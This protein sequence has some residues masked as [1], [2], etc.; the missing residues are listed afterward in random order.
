MRFYKLFIIT[1]FLTWIGASPILAG[2]IPAGKDPT[3]IRTG[4]W[5]GDFDLTSGVGFID[6]GKMTMEN[7]RLREN[8]TLNLLYKNPTFQFD[9]SI[10]TSFEK[11]ITDKTRIVLNSSF[12]GVIWNEESG[13]ARNGF[14]NAGA[15]WN[16]D[17]RNSY[18]VRA[19]FSPNHSLVDNST[20]K[21]TLLSTTTADMRLEERSTSA[22][23]SSVK[24]NSS[25]FL[26]KTRFSFHT[27]LDAG[28][29]MEKR[30]S[31]W[32][33]AV[34]KGDDEIEEMDI[35]DT[36]RLTPHNNRYNSGVS[37]TFRDSTLAGIPSLVAEA[38]LRLRGSHL[39]DH[40]SGAIETGDNEW[41][42][43]LRLRENFNY[44]EIYAEP[45][46]RLSYHKKKYG[47]DLNSTFQQYGNHLTDKGKDREVNW[48]PPSTIG[49]I[50][51]YW[52]PAPAHNLSVGGSRSIFHP[53][54]QQ[55]CWYDRQGAIEG[56]LFRGDPDLNPTVMTSGFL[57][58]Q[59]TIKKFRFTSR[60]TLTHTSDEIEQFFTDEKVDG[61]SYTIFKWDN[62]A[63]GDSFG[64]Q[65]GVSWSG[66]IIT[67][68]LNA[69]YLQ[70][71]RHKY[72]SGDMI[73][74]THRWITR[75]AVGVHPGHGW[76]FDVNGS[77]QGDIV[78]FYSI[79]KEYVSV[80]ARI[81]KRLG[82]ITLSL[83]GRDLL[84]RKRVVKVLSEDFSDSWEE[85][86]RM[87]RRLILLG[88]KWNF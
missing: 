81:S 21:L 15:R 48:R 60:S 18:S 82:K 84:D 76:D 51:F 28:T 42:D 23:S 69:D 19:S 50:R 8:G 12:F 44:I 63:Y 74:D 70:E 47:A 30:T 71:R 6:W 29:S 68:S 38:G 73:K 34:V 46:V 61:R 13:K 1:A 31:E 72:G 53:S 16:P 86:S 49:D 14:I 7:A 66:K 32:A 80:N 25:H 55:I 2:P 17:K 3:K 35:G 58:Y 20:A 37:L 85:E 62:T 45:N 88:V 79:I 54:Y 75:A 27:S 39:L 33:E 10:G 77:Y 22:Y 9:T 87:N 26:R 65:A 57:D 43:S 41:R 4:K 56:Q 83:D 59:L 36:Y 67:G 78:T 52:K 64:Q 24:F 11:N 40:Y 5:S